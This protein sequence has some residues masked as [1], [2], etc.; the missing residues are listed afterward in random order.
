MAI[1]I[2]Q[3]SDSVLAYY[4]AEVPGSTV[5]H[6]KLVTADTDLRLSISGRIPAAS[7]SWPGTRRSRPPKMRDVIFK[8]GGGRLEVP[9]DVLVA[10]VAASP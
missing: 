2:G 3:G 4:I 9:P 6:Q 10:E 5:R 1:D 7:P 8:G